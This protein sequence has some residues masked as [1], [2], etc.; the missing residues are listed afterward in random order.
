MNYSRAIVKKGWGLRDSLQKSPGVGVF[1][2]ELSNPLSDFKQDIINDV[3]T[4]LDTM[5]A[6]RKNED[7]DIML[8]KYFPHYEENKHNFWCKSIASLKP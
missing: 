5:Q 1:K 3:A 4:Q 7:A 6:W 2:I 8:A